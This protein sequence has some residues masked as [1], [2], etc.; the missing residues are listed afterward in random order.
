MQDKAQ[1][2]TLHSKLAYS[3]EQ[4]LWLS[5]FV[6]VYQKLSTDNLNLLEDIYHKNIT[7]IDPIHQIQGFENVYQYFESLYQNLSSCEFIITDVIAGATAE[8]EQAAIYW[9][10]TYQHHKFNQGKP[11]TV[12]GN[13][14]IKGQGDKVIYHRDFL[15][16]GVMIYEQ[17]PIL[18]KVIKWI[19]N[20]AAL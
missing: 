16:L 12:L 18:G 2:K 17:L 15:D 3:A 8:T 7:F 4:P 19:K 11:V 10:M 6:E 14:H 9:Q 1:N 13:S 5:N 20:K